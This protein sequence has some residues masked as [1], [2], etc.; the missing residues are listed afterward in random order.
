M[1][2]RVHPLVFTTSRKYK[3]KFHSL[4]Q[5]SKDKH[6]YLIMIGIKDLRRLKFI[7]DLEENIMR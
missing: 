1:I 7:I 2:K 5:R 4:F 6:W 3:V